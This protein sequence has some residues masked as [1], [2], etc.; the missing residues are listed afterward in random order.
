MSVLA[1]IKKFGR[2]FGALLYLI[3]YISFLI[4]F[5]VHDYLP[6]KDKLYKKGNCPVGL[7]YLWRWQWINSSPIMHYLHQCYFAQVLMKLTHG[8]DQLIPQLPLLMV[9]YF[10]VFGLWSLKREATLDWTLR[11]IRNEWIFTNSSHFLEQ[12][13]D[14]IFIPHGCE[15]WI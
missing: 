12:R 14:K 3:T 15:A 11:N 6:T 8:K 7:L 13:S 9:K 5:C 1:I 10:Y 4:W 2:K